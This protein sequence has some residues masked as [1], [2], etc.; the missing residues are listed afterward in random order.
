MDNEVLN[1]E[2]VRFP[3]TL[4]G[5]RTSF[6][7]IEENMTPKKSSSKRTNGAAKPEA[8]KAAPKQPTSK[9]RVRKIAAVPPAVPAPSAMSDEEIAR[10]AY[11]LWESRGRPHG[12]PEED[13]YR[14]KEQL[15]A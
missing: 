9:A 2:D 11:F 6:A 15:G 8:S 12:S 5:R 7:F 3:R 10:K 4:P 1:D 13:W 14:A